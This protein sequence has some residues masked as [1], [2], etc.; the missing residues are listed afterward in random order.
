MILRTAIVAEGQTISIYRGV[1]TGSGTV[2]FQAA[3]QTDTIILSTFIASIV[4]TVKIDVYTFSQ[5][6]ELKIIDV[7]LLSAVTP[8][9]ILKQASATLSNIRVDITHTGD[10]DIDIAMKGMTGGATSSI[11]IVG[12]TSGSASSA[13]VTAVAGVLIPASTVDRKGLIFKNWTPS[14]TLYVGFTLPTTTT[15]DGWPMVYGESLA[16]DIEA[17]Q[18]IYAVSGSGSIDVRILEVG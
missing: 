6:G 17:G 9:L 8:N 2:S 7:P 3:C 13:T 1:L 18:A 16:L 11:I 12:P 14:S 15:A 10:C 5:T 4:G